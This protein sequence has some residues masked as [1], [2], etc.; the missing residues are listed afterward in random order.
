[1]PVRVAPGPAE[2]SSYTQWL[3]QRCGV[4]SYADA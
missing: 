3:Y 4:K 1:M 2:S